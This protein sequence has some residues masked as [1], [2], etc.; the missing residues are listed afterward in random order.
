MSNDIDLLSL[1]RF[2][3]W[4]GVM[5]N[6]KMYDALEIVK[7][8]RHH[9]NTFRTVP[10]TRRPLTPA[11][12]Q[13]AMA[14]VGRLPKNP[15][16]MTYNAFESRTRAKRVNKAARHQTV[17]G[18]PQHTSFKH[19]I[20]RLATAMAKALTAYARPGT[21][22]SVGYHE[23]VDL[24]AEI[25]AA[26]DSFQRDGGR[27]VQRVL[28]GPIMTWRPSVRGSPTPAY[29]NSVMTKEIHRLRRA[30]TEAFRLYAAAGAGFYG[31][32][33]ELEHVITVIGSAKTAAAIERALFARLLLNSVRHMNA[34]RAP[35]F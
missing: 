35:R 23:L 8:V 31:S 1:E 30:V 25:E 5:L 19:Q 2:P 28:V 27:A 10:H 32:P 7:A 17:P 24:T 3:T 16:A 26:V 11:N 34:A 14:V 13:A 22:R 29:L 12:I 21:R 33:G 18:T 9:P 6:K 15:N 4:R 20:E